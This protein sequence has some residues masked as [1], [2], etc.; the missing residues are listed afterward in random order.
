VFQG[1]SQPPGESEREGPRVLL[2]DDLAES[3]QMVREFLEGEGINVVAEA[4]NGREAVSV[5]QEQHPDVVLMDIR[6]PDMDGLEATR[7]IKGWSPDTQIVMLSFYDEPDLQKAALRLGVFEFLVKGEAFL[8]LPEVIVD[9]WEH[10]ASLERWEEPGQAE[11]G[12][13]DF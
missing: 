6:M 12:A 2:V 5:V 9:A 8:R 7:K 10:K 11:S 1:R 3:R 4:G 13:S